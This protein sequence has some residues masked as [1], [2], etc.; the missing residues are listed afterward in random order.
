MTIKI[1]AEAFEQ[2]ILDSTYHERLIA[3]LPHL[4]QIA[5]IP[6]QMVWSRL[7]DFCTGDDLTWVRA[8]K[9]TELLGLAYTGTT[10]PPVS[11]KLMAIAGACLR[12]YID[13]RVMAVQDVLTYLKNDTMPA[14]TVLLI[15]NFCLDKGEGGDIAQWHIS[16]LLGLLYS[17]HTKNL[18]T[19]LYIGSLTSLEKNYGTA[20]R[21]HI[22]THFIVL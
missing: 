8:L 10:N 11:D 22:E 14:P 1:P 5:G 15:P 19:V 9:K 17:R 4:C 21:Q 13:A 3:D 7:S 12:N 18:K 2:K 16:S 6:P 20:F